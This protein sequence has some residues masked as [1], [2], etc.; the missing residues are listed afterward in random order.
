MTGYLR[1]GEYQLTVRTLGASAGHLGLRL[2]SVPLQDEGSLA[3][4]RPVRV[5]LPARTAA[6]YAFDVPTAGRYRIRS[7]GPGGAVDCRI[8]DDAGFPLA[9][10]EAA[11]AAPCTCRP[12]A[13][14]CSCCPAPP[15]P[16]A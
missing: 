1:A 12:A 2:R 7:V 11:A 15:R 5:R 6:R 10:A 14:T 8:E 3:V 16:C 4:G 9:P 13:G